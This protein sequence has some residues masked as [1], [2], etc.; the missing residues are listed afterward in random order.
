MDEPTAALTETEIEELFR[1]IR[2]LRD[3]RRGHRLH[4]APA[5]RAQ[6]DRR[7]RHRHAR[8]PLRRHRPDRGRPR[9]DQ[10]ISMMVGRTI[11]ESSPEVPGGPR[12]G[13]GAGGRATSTAARDQGRQLQAE[14]RRD[15]RLCRADGRGPHRGG[16]RRLRRRPGRLGRDAA[17][18]GKQVTSTAAATRCA[19]G[20]GYLSEDRKRY[21]LALGMDVETNIVLATFASSCGW[22]GWVNSAATRDD[23]GAV[24]RDA[25]DQDAQRC[26]SR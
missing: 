7:P 1:I 19:H 17:C 3:Q 10:I 12:P 6:A 11:Y 21:G 24:R 16:A 20:I 9:M 23:R 8:R 22:A 4:L 13:G 2:Q 25:L 18:G 5:G 26:S 15:P 14:A